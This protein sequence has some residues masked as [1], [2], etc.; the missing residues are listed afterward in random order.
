VLL[1]EHL[2]NAVLAGREE[3]AGY[4]DRRFIVGGIVEVRNLD[5]GGLMKRLTGFQ[6]PLGAARE[7]EADP[8][9]EHATEHRAGMPVATRRLAR[10]ELDPGHPHVV[11]GRRRVEAIF[12]QLVTDRWRGLADPGDA[13]RESGPAGVHV[14][15][16]GWLNSEVSRQTQALA[17]A[18]VVGAVIGTGGAR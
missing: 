2:D 11:D 6:D 15:P 5:A 10:R 18:A 16:L 13:S 12:E 7:L 14:S 1:I 9:R 8:A 17:G 3:V 4:E